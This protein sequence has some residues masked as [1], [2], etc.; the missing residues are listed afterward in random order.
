MNNENM[1]FSAQPVALSHAGQRRMRADVAE[2]AAEAR[3]LKRQLRRRWSEPMAAAQQ[4][5][6]EVKLAVTYRMIVLAASRGRF[7]VRAM[8]RLGSVPGTDQYYFR[9]PGTRLYSLVR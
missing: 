5:L 4:R 7:H 8:P 2:L 3:A 9:A 6:C 1:T